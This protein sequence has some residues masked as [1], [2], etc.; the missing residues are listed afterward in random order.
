MWLR[1][2]RAVAQLGDGVWLSWGTD[3]G[4]VGGMECGS[5]VGGLRLSRGWTVSQLWV[6]AEWDSIKCSASCW[7]N[8]GWY[9]YESITHGCIKRANNVALFPSFVSK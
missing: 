7:L 8:D 9:S 3:C 1:Q 4:S 5:V 2:G 6:E